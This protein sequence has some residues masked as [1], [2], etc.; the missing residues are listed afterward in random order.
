MPL[1]PSKD[2]E[3]LAP[4]ALWRSVL[5]RD[6]ARAR[7]ERR[8]AQLGPDAVADADAHELRRE[9]CFDRRNVRAGCR[10]LQQEDATLAGLWLCATE[11]LR[12]FRD[13]LRLEPSYRGDPE[14]IKLVLRG[15][16]TTPSY[17]NDLAA[18]LREEIGS[19]AVPFLE[20]TAR[21]H[22]NPMIRSRAVSELRRYH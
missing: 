21:D 7:C 16:I 4:L 17:N 8:V 9:L 15:F 6:H 22:P 11:G 12:S 3:E 19:A 2:T 5:F 14:L 18:F 10:V 13:A 1:E 20:E